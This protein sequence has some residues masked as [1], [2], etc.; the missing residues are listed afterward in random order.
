MFIRLGAAVR[1][2]ASVTMVMDYF[3]PRIFGIPPCDIKYGWATGRVDR[4]ISIET[5]RFI[6]EFLPCR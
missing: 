6:V 2:E 5:S 3:V 1:E 4:F